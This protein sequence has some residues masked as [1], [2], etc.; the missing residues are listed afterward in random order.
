[1][2]LLR[3]ITSTSV[4][5]LDPGET[6]TLP[7]PDLSPKPVR[8]FGHLPLSFERNE[9]Q[10]DD[11]A[12][13]LARG[14]GYQ[15]FL[16]QT[17]AVMVLHQPQRHKEHEAETSLCDLRALVVP[18]PAPH[19][20]RMKLVGANSSSLISGEEPLP[21]K[22]NYFIG[23]D[24]SRW[25]TNISTFARVR[26]HEVYPGIDLVYYGNEG[27][28]E[29]DFVIAPGADP[30][31]IALAIEGAD[32]IEVDERGDLRLEISG[33]ELHWRKPKSFQ[34]INGTQIEIAGDYAL[35]T[36]ALDLGSHTTHRV[37][38]HVA[39]YDPTQTLIIDPVL[40][41]S[42]YLGGGMKD[43]G[44]AIAVDSQGNAYVTGYTWSQSDFPTT[45]N[46]IKRT[47]GVNEAVFVTKLNPAGNRAIYST[48]LSGAA[49]V[50]EVSHGNAIAVDPA[51]RA[52]VYGETDAT[53]FPLKNALQ[54]TYG[55]VKDAFVAKLSPDGAG[56][57]FS[58]YL[59]GSASEYAGSLALDGAANIYVIGETASTDFPTA[60][61]FQAN[62]GGVWDEFV[63]K[64]DADGTRL[65][66][67]T[68]LGGSDYNFSGDAALAADAA[69]H[70]YVARSTSPPGTDV[71]DV[72]VEKFSL[73]GLQLEFSTSN[74]LPPNTFVKAIAVDSTGS[75]FLTGSVSENLATTPQAFQAAFGG[76]FSDSFVAKL[77]PT[78]SALDYL[79]YVGGI[80]GENPRAI[81]V[82]A[83]GNAYVA[84]GTWSTNFPIADP[85]QARLN[86]GSDVLSSGGTAPPS[87]A[88]VFKLTPDGRRLLWSTFLGGSKAPPSGINP[89]DEAHGIALGSDGAV[90][91]VGDTSSSDFPLQNPFQRS[92][93][94][95]SGVY[96][97]DVFVSKIIEAPPP[98]A[99]IARSGNSVTISWPVAA[100][101]F[102][103]ETNDSL[104]P[105]ANWF[106]EPTAPVIIADQNVATI[107][108]GS[109]P[110]FFRL[111]KP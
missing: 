96:A 33:Q 95:Q 51:G 92:L 58:T 90:Y 11:K 39:A 8:S 54:T 43:I 71:A 97:R 38:F 35:Q 73:D 67:S 27:Q 20:L 89:A 85:L 10:A 30:N 103:L 61:P 23:S 88:F 102:G 7:L 18:E 94:V 83:V 64:I 74:F 98:S 81:T 65:V 77:N 17:E 104:G 6:L 32:K 42:T 2:L 44:N 86:K 45:A 29:Y 59:G 52:V 47:F 100:A 91:V 41:Y 22:F 3:T 19:F 16:A 82:D 99:Q 49:S 60:S 40:A 34:R 15:L 12:K 101:G 53:D 66:Y 46:S 76:G 57:I 107:E 25:R 70:A 84:G 24:P 78:G 21:G 26:Y 75:A 31:R 63:A 109:S 87:D 37:A 68:Y 4:Q 14:P 13:F 1:M 48:I 80:D 36:P 79:T 106:V 69:G 108:I 50:F 5:A 55:G 28:L 93:R 105:A 110:K 9:G 56:L 72:F 111:R 62:P